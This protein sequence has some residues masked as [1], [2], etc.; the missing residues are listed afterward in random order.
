MSKKDIISQKKKEYYEKNKEKILKERQAYYQ[1]NKDSILVRNKK[2]YEKHKDEYLEYKKEYYQ[3]NRDEMLLSQK[4]DRKNNP[5]KYLLKAAKKRA[6]K[7][8]LPFNI[9]IEDIIIPDVCPV[10]GFTLE[11][12]TISERDNSPSLD[13]IIP[14]LGYV[15]G[16]VKV[17]S[18]K[19]N[20]LKRDGHIEE[21]K[22]IISYIQENKDQ[23]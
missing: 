12:G 6:K 11:V 20:T 7:K 4:I 13:K 8:N 15:K 14:E 1:N 23:K 18:F 17:I 5:E 10:F 9:E 22:K 16:N 19:A 21:F 3:E 2:N